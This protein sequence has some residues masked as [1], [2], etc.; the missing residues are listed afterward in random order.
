MSVSTITGQRG[1]TAGR[2]GRYQ[3]RRRLTV[4]VGEEKWTRKFG[5]RCKVASAEMRGPYD[6]GDDGMFQRASRRRSHS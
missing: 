2:R 4:V 1:I 5:Q 6:N 3:S